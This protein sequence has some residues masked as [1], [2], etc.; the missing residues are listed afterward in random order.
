MDD[1][2]DLNW[3][4]IDAT[5]FRSAEVKEGKQ[6]EFLIRDFFP[7]SLIRRIGIRSIGIKPR[8]DAAL[9]GATHRPKLEIRRE[10]YY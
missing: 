5:D 9:N 3:P 2:G 8:V 7:W 1:L 10:W 4:A 6:A